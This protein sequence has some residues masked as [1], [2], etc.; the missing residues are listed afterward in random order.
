MTFN[1]IYLNQVESTQSYIIEQDKGSKMKEF[2]VFCTFNQTMGKGQGEHKWESEK[3]KNISFSL[4]VRPK[5]I[6]PSEQ[7]V[8]TQIASLSVVDML[9]KYIKD[10]V[11]IKWPNDIYVKKNKICG[12]LVQNNVI[13]N[14]F[15]G[16]Y[17]GIGIN[18]NQK[19]FSFAPNPTSIAMETNK[20]YDLDVILNE[21]LSC[22]ERRYNQL[23]QKNIEQLKKEYLSLLLYR[24]IIKHYIYKGE[25]IEAKI[26]DVNEYGYLIMTTKQGKNLVCEMKELQFIH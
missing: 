20:E 1:I 18:V 8:L 9:K 10:E 26:K 3:G 15:L 12:M 14:E 23:Q 19:N 24:N 21:F 16:V 25:E 6:L 5:F 7:F 2:T 13:G 22:F 4:L 17:F 11:Y